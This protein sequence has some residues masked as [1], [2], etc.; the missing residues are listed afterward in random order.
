MNVYA[1]CSLHWLTRISSFASWVRLFYARSASAGAILRIIVSRATSYANGFNRT[2]SITE[3]IAVLFAMSSVR[4]LI[5]AM[6]KPG[7]WRTMRAERFQIV[8]ESIHDVFRRMS[9]K[10][11]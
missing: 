11:V 4:A 6:V 8:Q 2:V 3:N 1:R 5:T 7:A 9:R 10:L